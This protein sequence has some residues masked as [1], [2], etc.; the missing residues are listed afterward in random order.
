M[1]AQNNYAV[2]I[3]KRGFNTYRI[4]ESSHPYQTAP[5][6]FGVAFVIL[7]ETVDGG[8]DC[9]AW[10]LHFDEA[11]ETYFTDIV[12]IYDDNVNRAVIFSAGT[13]WPGTNLPSMRVARSS[14]YI[15][16]TGPTSY[17]YVT[18]AMSM[19]LY[20]FKMYCAPVY[21][22]YTVADRTVIRGNS[23]PSRYFISSTV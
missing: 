21:A 1:E 4:V 9:V 14:F 15:E 20:G 2:L 11:T 22:N 12:T 17:Q 23:A 6:T 16:F 19:A 13:D 5:P 10:D 18:A 3:D 7:S 8:D